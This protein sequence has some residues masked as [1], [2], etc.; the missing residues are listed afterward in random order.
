M[1]DWV[2]FL[3][4]VFTSCFCLKKKTSASGASPP[5]PHR[6]RCPLDPSGGLLRPPGPYFSADFSILNS[7]AWKRGGGGGG[8]EKDKQR[9]GWAVTAAAATA[10][11]LSRFKHGSDD[12]L[13]CCVPASVAVSFPASAASSGLP[14]ARP[15]LCPCGHPS[16]CS[17]CLSCPWR[18]SSCPPSPLGF[19][20]P[21]PLGLRPRWC[22]G[23][24]GRCCCRGCRAGWRPGCFPVPHSPHSW[25]S[26]SDD[27]PASCRW[28][29]SSGLCGPGGPS[30]CGR[31]AAPARRGFPAPSAR[32]AAAAW[33]GPHPTGC[34]RPR[35]RNW[36]W[37]WPDPGPAG[38]SQGSWR[39]SCRCPRRA[40]ARSP[41]AALAVAGWQRRRW[42]SAAVC[43]LCWCFCCRR[44]AGGRSS[45]GGTGTAVGGRG[46]GTCV[47]P[48][49][50]R[51]VDTG[52]WKMNDR[53]ASDEMGDMGWR[54]GGGGV[55]WRLR[56]RGGGS[57][58]VCK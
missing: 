41:G 35:W 55:G 19:L 10:C 46:S 9:K 28:H 17:S 21:R 58:W 53:F 13:A 18:A 56:W 52:R 2:V 7:H 27:G 33:R 30:L 22:W 4:A 6:G 54:W 3:C 37:R 38:P 1:Q 25:K 51:A 48:P 47:W 42:R 45:G 26:S 5:D 8:E 50:V 34:L 32:A 31:T 40:T 23:G 16:S 24:W 44:T 36:H 57:E 39:S 15:C 20:W 14:V 43:T 12:A 29:P 11:S 49:A